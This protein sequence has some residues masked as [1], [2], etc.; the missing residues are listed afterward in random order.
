M[1]AGAPRVPCLPA[2]RPRNLERAV[3]APGS[4]IARRQRSRGRAASACSR[5][6]GVAERRAAIDAQLH[7]A[8]RARALRLPLLP[9][10]GARPDRG[11]RARARARAAA[12]RSRRARAGRSCTRCSRRSTSAPP[13]ARRRAGRGGPRA[14]ARACARAPRS[15]RRSPALI[16]GALAAPPRRAA[17]GGRARAPRAPVRVRARPRRAGEPL[18]PA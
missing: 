5:R 7:L 10:T 2:G 17:G 11:S 6:P 13:R 8:V 15:A 14:R 3:P 18:S 9:R 1:S 12:G 16:A 4:C